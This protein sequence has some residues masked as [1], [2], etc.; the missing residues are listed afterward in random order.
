MSGELRPARRTRGGTRYYAVANLVSM[1]SAVIADG[2]IT[3]C[4]AWVSDISQE[5]ELDRQQALMA[6]YCAVKVGWRLSP[7]ARQ[8]GARRWL[9]R[10]G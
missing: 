8:S 2:A 5:A 10:G 4:Y 1:E 6:T 9:G 7:A 3:V